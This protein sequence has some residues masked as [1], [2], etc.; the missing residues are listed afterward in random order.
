MQIHTT[1]LISLQIAATLFRQVT[2]RAPKQHLLTLE[3]VLTQNFRRI[4]A[5]SPIDLRGLVE[6]RHSRLFFFAH[7]VNHWGGN[8][9][10]FSFHL[11]FMRRLV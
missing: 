10:T 7:V 6:G 1:I 5:K 11:I 4:M 3:L 9:F 8:R 2:T